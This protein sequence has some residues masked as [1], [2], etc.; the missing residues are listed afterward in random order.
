MP[1]QTTG[2][3]TEPSVA[4]IVPLLLMALLQTGKPISVQRLH[5]AHAGV[6]HQGPGAARHEAGGQQVAEVAVG[7]SAVMAATTMSPGWI[8]SATTCIIQLSP[9]CSSTVTAV[10]R[11]GAGIDRPHVGLHQADAAHGLVH[12][13]AAERASASAVAASVRVMLR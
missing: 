3:F 6:D 7:A 8:C 11:P 10:P 13:G 5:V 9:G 4:L 2:M 1:A 12:R